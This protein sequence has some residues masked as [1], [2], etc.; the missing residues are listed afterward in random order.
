MP[1][2]RGAGQKTVSKNIREM[3]RSGH[4]PE[5]AKAAAMR[6]KRKSQRRGR[7]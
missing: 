6:Q 3:I 2:A 5:Q 7:K 1:L 4:P